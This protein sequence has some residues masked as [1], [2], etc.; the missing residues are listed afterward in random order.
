M[1]D[2][3]TRTAFERG[4]FKLQVLLLAFFFFVLPILLGVEISVDITWNAEVRMCAKL[5]WAT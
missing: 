1:T 3:R 2:T 4:F 5:A